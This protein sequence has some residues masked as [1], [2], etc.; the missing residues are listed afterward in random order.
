MTPPQLSWRNIAFAGLAA[1]A[2]VAASFTLGNKGDTIAGS[3]NEGPAG[4]TTT[5][6]PI[7]EQLAL[8]TALLSTGPAGTVEEPIEAATEADSSLCHLAGFANHSASAA[9]ARLFVVDNSAAVIAST[10]G[11]AAPP[12]ATPM[13]AEYLRTYPSGEATDLIASIRSAAP[14]CSSWSDSSG[15]WTLTTVS[16]YTADA[17]PFLITAPDGSEMVTSYHQVASRVLTV[18]S[19]NTDVVS[20]AEFAN[21]ATAHALACIGAGC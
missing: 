12:A 3:A 6:D 15:T 14:G 4:S 16:G 7:N 11:N 9:S 1:V 18:V 20:A 2:V 21:A 8:E 10:Y 19:A 5:I 17:G 13:Y